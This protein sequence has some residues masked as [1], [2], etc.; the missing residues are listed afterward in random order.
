MTPI[1]AIRAF[2]LSCCGDNA[3]EVKRCSSPNCPL[4]SFRLGHNP[5]IQ[6]R[7]LTDQQRKA[8]ADRLKEARAK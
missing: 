8:M 7:E 5:N 6:A 1:K 2:C 3:N 4:F